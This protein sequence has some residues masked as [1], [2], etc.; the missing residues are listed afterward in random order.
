MGQHRGE[1]DEVLLGKAALHEH[2]LAHLLGQLQFVVQPLVVRG[3]G[4]LF[5]H[6]DSKAIGALFCNHLPYAV[7]PQFLF[8]IIHQS[9][10]K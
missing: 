9:K 8:N 1:V 3:E 5:R 7:E 6:T 10:S 4:H 2:N